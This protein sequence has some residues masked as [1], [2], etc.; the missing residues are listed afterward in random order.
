[1]YEI[2][3]LA[4]GRQFQAAAGAQQ[5]KHKYQAAGVDV[6][7]EVFQ[8]AAAATQKQDNQHYPSAV[9]SAAAAV[10]VT[11]TAAA[12]V[13]QTVEHFYL[14]FADLVGFSIRPCTV[15]FTL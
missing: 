3:L 1:M 12:V 6:E 9:A 11:A 7:I 13:K 8:L 15:C 2:V 10:V 14:R 4:V 5:C